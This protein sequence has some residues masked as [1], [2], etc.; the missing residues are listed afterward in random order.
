[1]NCK[2]CMKVIGEY[3][4]GELGERI[5]GH[6]AA[7]LESCAACAN[8]Y[9]KIQYEQTV[10][11]TVEQ[12]FELTHTRW[13][14][15]RSRIDAEKAL[16]LA[17][18]F[19]PVRR[20]FPGIQITAPVAAAVLIS[21][22]SVILVVALL[23]NTSTSDIPSQR[24]E[25]GSVPGAMAT[26]SDS[27]RPPTD[28]TAPVVSEKITAPAR[29]KTKARIVPAE[30]KLLVAQRSETPSFDAEK[31]RDPQSTTLEHIEKSQMLLRSF[32]NAPEDIAVERQRFQKLLNRNVLLRCE[33]IVKGNLLEEEVLTSLEP[34]LIDI[35]N[36]PDGASPEDMRSI[37][38]TMK[39]TEIVAMLRVYSQTN[40][41]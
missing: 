22:I 7:H 35:T 41:R 27:P 12:H 31:F 13:E 6:V 17:V 37:T 19:T 26:G 30:R 24:A 23:N 10:Y 11:A 20:W 28:R 1:M 16:T 4:D 18:P 2:A 33:A 34:I 9:E 25:I 15:V 3:V 29:M 21:I 8:A 14:T 32:R 5:A 40:N 36:L 38:E 39:K